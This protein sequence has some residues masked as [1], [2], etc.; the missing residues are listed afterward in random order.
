MHR[1]MTRRGAAAA[2]TLASLAVMFLPA[3]QASM[4][5]LARQAAASTLKVG[6][7]LDTGGRNDK[8]FNQLAFQGAEAAQAKYG[9]Q[10]DS[11][12]T[13]S[14]S[15]ALYFQ[16]LSTYARGGYSLVIGV[17]FLMQ[18]AMYKAAKAYPATKFALIDGA[19]TDPKGN[20]VNLKNVANLRFREQE[21]GYLVGYMAGLMEK[22]KVG[23]ATHGVIGTMGGMPIPPVNRYIAGYIQGARAADPGI[24]IKL[25]YVGDFISTQKANNIGQGQVAEGADILFAVAGGA[26]NSYLKAAQQKG[27][28][29]IGVDADQYFLGSYMMT[30][31]VKKVDKAVLLEI[32][33]VKSGSFKG[34]D[35]LFTLK[36]NAT[37]YGTIGKMVP[38]N[39]VAQVKAQEALI[40]AGT[41]VPTTVIPKTL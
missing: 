3:N 5:V 36:N 18:N 20:T 1:F 25:G 41:L 10:F 4:H 9:I 6:L 15:D 13:T 29:G 31:A 21:S 7:V 30:S 11:V 26:G 17:G 2:I 8:S 32:G 37:G 14:V 40:A 27:V 38:A 34:G 28:Y 22:G 16:N 12:V 35:N 24:K 23:A 39:I 33:A 19:P